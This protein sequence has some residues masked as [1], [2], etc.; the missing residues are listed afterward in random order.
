M[1]EINN[2][3]IERQFEPFVHRIHT[4]DI[5]GRPTLRLVLV[6]EKFLKLVGLLEDNEDV[7]YVYAD[8]EISDALVVKMGG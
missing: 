8:F 2:I 1:S 7:Q 6:G 5:W 3:A 4:I